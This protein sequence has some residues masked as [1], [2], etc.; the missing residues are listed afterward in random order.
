MCLSVCPTLVC[1]CYIVI[2]IHA[3]L[4]SNG[5]VDLDLGELGSRENLG[6]VWEGETIIKYILLKKSISNK[7]WTKLKYPKGKNK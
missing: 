2:I 5:R 4:Y 3:Y 7:I 6:G 1:F